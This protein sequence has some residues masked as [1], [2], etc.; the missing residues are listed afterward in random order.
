MEFFVSDTHFGHANV[1]KYCDRPFESVEGM[2][3]TLVANW[4]SVVQQDDIVYH[5]G[6]FSFMNEKET[7]K[8]IQQLNG[9]KHLIRGNH[10]KMF[11]KSDALHKYFESVSD[12]KEIHVHLKDGSSQMIVLCHFPMITWH[13]IHRG[14]WMIHGHCHGNLKPYPMKAKIMDAGVD[15]CGFFPISLREVEQHMSKL[16]WEPIDHHGEA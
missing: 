12:Y 2:N 11:K 15:P 6:D 1:I 4:N 9:R 16:T 5:T 3:R 8:V 7:E 13:K 10:D 14:S